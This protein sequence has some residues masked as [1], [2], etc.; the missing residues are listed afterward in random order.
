MLTASNEFIRL[1]RALIFSS[2]LANLSFILLSSS[3]S[4]SSNSCCR[5]SPV[6]VPVMAFPTIV[7]KK[8]KRTTTPVICF[9]LRDGS[10]GGLEIS[11]F[12]P[13]SRTGGLEILVY[14][15]RGQNEHGRKKRAFGVFL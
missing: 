14:F 15:V 5:V 10:S 4:F 3:L 7:V 8:V 2:S 6:V 1:E 9:F 12:D 11:P 13:Y